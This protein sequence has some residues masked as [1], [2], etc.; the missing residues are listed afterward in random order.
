[1]FTFKDD[2]LG[3]ISRLLRVFLYLGLL[4]ILHLLRLKCECEKDK[5]K[6]KVYLNTYL[7]SNISILRGFLHG[8][9][10]SRI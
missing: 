7:F 9:V 3:L 8:C 6:K 5:E 2:P 4:L 10:K 1:M